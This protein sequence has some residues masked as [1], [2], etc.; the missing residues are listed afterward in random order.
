MWTQ[1]WLIFIHCKFREIW[2]LRPTLIVTKLGLFVFCFEHFKQII[3]L[4]YMYNFLIMMAAGLIGI[5][6]PLYCVKYTYVTKF[7]VVFISLYVACIIFFI[8][9]N[10]FVYYALWFVSKTSSTFSKPV[11]TWLHILSHTWCWL[12]THIY[13]NSDWLCCLNLLWLADKEYSLWTC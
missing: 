11:M 3:N 7:R 13:L 8:C 9:W 1:T 6:K 10:A 4:Q 5:S 12:N 2:I